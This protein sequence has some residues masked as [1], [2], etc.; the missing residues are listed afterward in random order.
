VAGGWLD[1]HSGH[2][3]GGEECGVHVPKDSFG[4]SQGS[5]DGMISSSS[6]IVARNQFENPI[7]DDP[8][9][10]RTLDRRQPTDGG[11]GKK[12]FFK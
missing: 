4:S 10:A 3:S 6:R 9:V 2:Y 7:F 12:V 5:G 8:D 1:S 11:M